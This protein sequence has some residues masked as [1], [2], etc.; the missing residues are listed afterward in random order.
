MDATALKEKGN[1]FYKNGQVLEGEILPSPS[2][3]VSLTLH[4]DRSIL[5]AAALSPENA[6]PGPALNPRTARIKTIFLVIGR[7][8]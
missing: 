1:T 7:E 6:L 5:E 4:S 2:H 8:E 3:C